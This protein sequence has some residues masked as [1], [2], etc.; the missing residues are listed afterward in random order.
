MSDKQAKSFSSN[1]G[2]IMAAVGSAVGL[3]NIWR[4]PY[5]CGQYGGG[6]FIV[7]YLLFVFLLG[8]VLMMSEFVLG[9]R[10]HHSH[11]LSI[12]ASR[13]ERSSWAIVGVVGVVACF[14]ILSLYLVLSGWTAG[15][16][17]DSIT[18]TLSSLGIDKDA[19]DAHFVDFST[20]S[21]RSTLFLLVF[22]VTV[23]FVILGGVQ[24]GIETVSKILMPCLVLI[25]LVL[26]VHNLFLP[27][28]SKG[29]QFLFSTDFSKLTG[30]GILAAL[31]QALFSLSVGMGVMVVY[32]SYIPVDDNIFKTAMWIT[33]SDTAIAILAGVAIFPAVF[34]CGMEPAGGPGL[35][36]KVLPTVFNSMGSVGVVFSSLFF[37]L[38]LVAALTS[39]IS[40]LET[41]TACFCEHTKVNRNISAILFFFLSSVCGVIISLSN[42]V[43][44]DFTIFGFTIFDFVDK[45]NSIYLPPL[46]AL[47]IILFVG[48]VMDQKTLKDELSNHGTISIGYYPVFRLLARYVVPVALLVVIVTGI[49]GL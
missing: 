27:G 18:G 16:F 20:S 2:A 48:W 24:Q 7:V 44:S 31:G 41:L 49:L 8:S 33:V 3:G 4:F 26:A 40:L 13:G 28:A 11:I 36:F 25:V 12:P 38:L 5:I 14:S 39:A 15:F 45:L 32:G 10:S 21:L 47:G 17:W 22:S 37:F 19:V 34:A 46:G 23:L 1:I 35:V 29:L 6:A 30:E 43:L 9:R 42:G